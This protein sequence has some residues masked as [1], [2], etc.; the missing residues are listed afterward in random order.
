MIQPVVVLAEKNLEPLRKNLFEEIQLL[1]GSL[2][3]THF[4]TPYGT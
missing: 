1:K 2:A 4:A 3:R